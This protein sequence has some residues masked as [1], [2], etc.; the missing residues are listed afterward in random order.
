MLMVSKWSAGS[1][2]L[3][4]SVGLREVNMDT[5]CQANNHCI[6]IY[7]YKRCELRAIGLLLVLSVRFF[8]FVFILFYYYSCC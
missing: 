6:Y 1:F 8:V 7:I 5:Q 2:C 4:L 3:E